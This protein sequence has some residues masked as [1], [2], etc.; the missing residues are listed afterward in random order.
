MMLAEVDVVAWTAEVEALEFIRTI[1]NKLFDVALFFDT[2]HAHLHSK[3][4]SHL[5]DVLDDFAVAF[6]AGRCLL[7]ESV[8]KFEGACLE[9]LQVAQ[10]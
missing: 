3:L 10:V 1:F 6:V 7:N 8:V 5:R 2:F 9:I 4:V